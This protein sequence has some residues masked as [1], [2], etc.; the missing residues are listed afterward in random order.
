MIFRHQPLNVLHH[1]V[2]QRPF[3]G[4]ELVAHP[5]Q[6]DVFYLGFINDFLQGMC[7]VGNDHN[8]RRAAVI[9]LVLQFARGIQ[10]VNVDGNHSGTQDPKQR[11][12][13]LQ[14]V[15]HHQRDAIALL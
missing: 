10:R 3:G 7:E 6:D 4:G 12:R 8:R 9:E 13:V 14:Q 1:K 15:R 2:D 5:R 11:H